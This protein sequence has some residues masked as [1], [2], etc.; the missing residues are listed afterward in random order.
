MA[1]SLPRC[2][3]TEL[4]GNWKSPSRWVAAR[5]SMY[6]SRRTDRT[7]WKKLIKEPICL[8]YNKIGYEKNDFPIAFAA[9]A[10]RAGF[11]SST[12]CYQPCR[13]T[14]MTT[15]RTSNPLRRCSIELASGTCTV[16]F[17]ANVSDIRGAAQYKFV[18]ADSWKAHDVLIV[19]ET[20]SS[21]NVS[22]R[23]KPYWRD[24]DR[25]SD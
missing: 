25:A 11:G 22:T 5:R 4:P 23:N 13:R 10:K 7:V 8:L 12:Y 1:G 16:N 17:G 2:L 14:S 19:A 24:H 15:P 3:S 9:Y 18:K 6:R 21:P 20:A